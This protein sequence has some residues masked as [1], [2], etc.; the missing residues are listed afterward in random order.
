LL[1]IH[2]GWATERELELIREHDVKVVAAPSSSL[3]NAYGNIRMGHLPE[4]IEQGVA[5]GLGSDHA[6]SGIVDLPQEMF[7]VACAYKEVRENP[8]VMPPERAVEMATIN[9]ARCMLRES[10]IGSLEVGKRADLTIFDAR[11]PEW[12]PLYNPIANLV[13]SA[14]GKSVDTVIVDGRIL[15]RRG[16]VLTL[17]EEAIIEAAARRAPEIL[18]RTRLAKP[19]APKWP[20]V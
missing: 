13:Y 1:L 15:M 7:L 12:Q 19:I 2:A 3:H 11:R 4:L 10:E 9:G 18:A 17:D 5:V 20:V 16:R 6:S 14:T 8:E